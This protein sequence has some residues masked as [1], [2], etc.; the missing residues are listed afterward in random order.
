MGP[1]GETIEKQRIGLYQHVRI[2]THGAISD[3]GVELDIF[4]FYKFSV[5]IVCLIFTSKSNFETCVR[6]SAT[7]K[8]TA[9]T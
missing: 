9:Q 4:G 2:H 3:V 1:D 8:M 7:G 6:Q 5:G